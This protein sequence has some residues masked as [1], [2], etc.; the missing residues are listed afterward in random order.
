MLACSAIP[1]QERGAWPLV[2]GHAIDVDGSSMEHGRFPPPIARRRQHGRGRRGPGQRRQSTY[3]VL[4]TKSPLPRR[5]PPPLVTPVA[6][7]AS[8]SA[9]QPL[10]PFHHVRQPLPIF[11]P[12]FCDK[13][14]STSPTSYS[15]PFY[16]NINK[17]LGNLKM[18]MMFLKEWEKKDRFWEDCW[19]GD[20]PLQYNFPTMYNSCFDK[21][22]SLADAWKRI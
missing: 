17:C 2:C 7:T 5:Y 8:A 20:K 3:Y 19:L 22:L 21:N 18:V 4:I 13:P 16:F 11:F 6:A 14:A 1:H 15:F 9:M 10:A 12:P